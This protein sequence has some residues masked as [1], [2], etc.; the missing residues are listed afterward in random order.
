MVLHL[1][2]CHYIAINKTCIQNIAKKKMSKKST[3][4]SEF[5][6]PAMDFHLLL[7]PNHGRIS[8][9]NHLVSWGFP[10]IFGHFYHIV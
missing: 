10:G 6:I 4:F 2:Q 1:Y 3:L 7:A 5:N 9:L 8:Q